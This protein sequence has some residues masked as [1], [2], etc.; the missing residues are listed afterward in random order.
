MPIVPSYTDLR[1]VTI[2]RYMIYV[3]GLRDCSQ[4]EKLLTVGSCSHNYCT[5]ENVKDVSGRWINFSEDWQT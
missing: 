4:N 2:K 5:F 1:I 3:F